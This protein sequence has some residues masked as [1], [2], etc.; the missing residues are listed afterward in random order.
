MLR[1]LTVATIVLAFCMCLFACGKKE[2]PIET[3]STTEMQT[4]DSSIPEGYEDGEYYGTLKIDSVD[5]ELPIYCAEISGAGISA[6]E[7][8]DAEDSGAYFKYGNQWVIGDHD[9]QG[10]DKI[11]TVSPGDKATIEKPQGKQVFECVTTANGYNI[12]EIYVI[13]SSAQGQEFPE[14]FS[15]DIVNLFEFNENYLVMYTCNGSTKDIY[16]TFWK[17][18]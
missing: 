14:K 5:L 17:Q 6:Q 18:L 7:I 8:T 1:K 2:E 4:I 16:I 3:T 10:F 13:L 11:L 15:E 12:A 9:Y